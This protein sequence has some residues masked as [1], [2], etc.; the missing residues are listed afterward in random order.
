M[1]DDIYSSLHVELEQLQ[2]DKSKLDQEQQ[3]LEIERK[4]IALKLQHINLKKNGL[5]LQISGIQE[6]LQGQAVGENLS[7]T[8]ESCAGSEEGPEASSFSGI[9]PQANNHVLETAQPVYTGTKDSEV[10]AGGDAIPIAEPGTDSRALIFSHVDEHTLLSLLEL[11]DDYRVI[12][13]LLVNHFGDELT[14]RQFVG[15]GENTLLDVPSMGRGKLETCLALKSALADAEYFNAAKNGVAALSVAEPWPDKALLSDLLINYAALNDGQQKLVERL[16]RKLDTPLNLMTVVHVIEGFDASDMTRIIAGERLDT[17]FN[18]LCGLLREAVTPFVDKA[19]DEIK[20]LI[21]G[22]SLLSYAGA[23]TFT[24]EE[25][26]GIVE[27]D[28]SMFLQQSDERDSFI[29]RSRFGLDGAELQTLQGIAD[30]LPETI[31]RERVRQLQNMALNK[32]LCSLS[33]H[34]VNI[35]SNVRDNLVHDIAAL[36]PDLS[37]RFCTEKGF[38][39]FIEA[40]CSAE[41]GEV[42]AL[43][44]PECTP[45]LLNEIAERCESPI[46]EEVIVEAIVESYGYTQQQSKNALQ[47]IV[48]GGR[49]QMDENGFIPSHLSKPQAVAQAALHFPNGGPFAEL[50]TFA[51]QQ[52]Y[53]ESVFPLERQDHGISGAVEMGLLYQSSRGT[54]RHTNF[55]KLDDQRIQE[56]VSTVKRILEVSVEKGID[57]LNLRIGVYERASFAEDYY[58]VRHIVREYGFEKGVYFNGKSGA[59]TISLDKNFSLKGQKEAIVQ[60]FERDPSP[61]TREDIATIIRSGS[62][63]HASFYI[64]TLIEEKRLVRVDPIHYDLPQF[65]FSDA[66]VSMIMER[67]ESMLRKAGKPVE[68]GIVAE[69]CNTRLHLQHAKAWY[70]SLLRIYSDQYRKGWAFHR[71]L[72]SVKPIED[73]SLTSF[74][75]KYI[76][77]NPSG[78]VL[79]VA[80]NRFLIDEIVLKRS[81]QNVKAMLN[82]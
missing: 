33:V 50:H 22:G 71:N 64:H 11:P 45:V 47:G 62:A 6:M 8:I 58:V 63:H 60:L 3:K 51:N 41:K 79:E 74:L 2:V 37:K 54:Y 31:T 19:E 28:L 20:A 35:W 55:L 32:L 29:I 61:R 73:K 17:V 48:G 70:L 24:T 39:Q 7:S 12:K 13:R 68:I 26:A 18:G 16:S 34:P 53:C 49:W 15:L 21:T 38:L 65:A 25:L 30:L 14:C 80:K 72:I 66:P 59:D 57:T 40:I 76:V 77:E 42:R 10:E 69:E 46:A 4:N 43:I 82:K 81:V 44:N 56:I 23:L 27:Q 75:R 5:D 78:D 1:S 52:G 67:A 9:V 36:Y